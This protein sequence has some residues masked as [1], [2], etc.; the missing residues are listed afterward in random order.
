MASSSDGPQLFGRDLAARFALHGH[1]AGA[2]G[3]GNCRRGR[4]E[5]AVSC[6]V[7]HGS[8]VRAPLFADI[9]AANLANARLV[10]HSVLCY[11]GPPPSIPT[12]HAETHDDYFVDIALVLAAAV[13]AGACHGIRR[14]GAEHDAV[15]DRLHP[16]HDGPVGRRPANRSK[17]RSKLWQAQNGT[18]V[19]GRK[20]EVIVRDDATT[21]DM[22]R[23]IAQEM[24]VNDKVD[25][26][27][28][29]G[30]TP[31]AFA[32]APIATQS[33]T[34]MV[35]TARRHL[36][37]HRAIALHR[38]HQLHPATGDGADRR[39]GGQARDQDGGHLRRRLR[40]RH[41]RREILQEP[42][43]ARRRQDHGRD[44]HAA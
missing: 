39:L 5:R 11:I 32:A 17:A 35:V 30:I 15:Q 38:A 2:P 36:L 16:A 42:V 44:P 22:T 31:S 4:R 41:R 7:G 24:V 18:T 27:A 23:R 33:K 13:L 8:I 40:P 21:P 25:V 14:C 6:G 28:G 37:D 26:L 10:S 9:A 29:F 34:P 1:R 3:A 20:V 12:E 19:G 43:R